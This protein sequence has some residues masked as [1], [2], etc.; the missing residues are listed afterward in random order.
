[1]LTDAKLKN[2]KGREL[3]YKVTDQKSPS[4]YPTHPSGSKQYFQQLSHV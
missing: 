2:L 4:K 1:M 3:P